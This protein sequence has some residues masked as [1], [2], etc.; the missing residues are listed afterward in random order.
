MPG[1]SLILAP[2]YLSQPERIT[3]TEYTIRVD[4]W[5]M[6]LSI[7]E[8]VQNRFPFPADLGP[9]ELIMH[10]TTSEVW[11]S[12]LSSEVLAYFFFCLT[13]HPD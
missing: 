3:G 7:L 10:I 4:V 2:H 1:P 9:L 13:S 12:V 11:I 5:S 8:L 6:G